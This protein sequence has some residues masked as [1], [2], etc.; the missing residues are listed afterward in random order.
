MSISV[1]R[2]TI[3]GSFLLAAAIYLTMVLFTL[4]QIA[5]FANGAMAFDMRP[6]GYSV[7]EAKH[8]LISLGQE[9]RQFYL[10]QQLLL[11]V[12]YPALLGVFLFGSLNKLA[13][14]ASGTWRMVL[15]GAAII[16][17]LA[18]GLDYA[19]NISIAMMLLSADVQAGLVQTASFFTI[20]KSVITTAVFVVLLIGAINQVLAVRLREPRL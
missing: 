2:I 19:E 10:S 9:G 13:S 3:L 15:I 18:I 4:P 14:L 16:S 7:Q 5:Q 20:A 17:I 1:S 8:F 6:S 12:F 11:D